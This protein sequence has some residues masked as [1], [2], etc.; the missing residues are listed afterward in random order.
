MIAVNESRHIIRL[1]VRDLLGPTRGSSS[2]EPSFAGPGRGRLGQDVHTVYLDRR[3]KEARYR[4]EVTV[5]WSFPWRGYS[6]EI[7]GRLDGLL[8]GPNGVTV[9]EVKSTLHSSHMLRKMPAVKR[10]AEQCGFYCLMLHHSGVEIRRGVVVYVSL[11]DGSERPVDI[12]FDVI[13]Y[14]QLLQVRLDILIAAQV[15]KEELRDVRAEYAAGMTFPFAEIRD[16]QDIM[17]EDVRGVAESG[18]TLLCS[19]PTGT[20]KTVAAL[21]PMVREALRVNTRLFFVTAKV[22]QQELAL[23]TLRLILKPE[24]R[25]CAVQITSKERTCPENDSRCVD[26]RC[27]A[28]DN[29]YF[30]LHRSGIL[31]DLLENPVIDRAMIEEAAAAHQFCA[32]ELSLTLAEYATVIVADFNYVFDPNVQLK[33]FFDESFSDMLLVVDEAHNLPK[34]AQ[35]YYSPELDVHELRGFIPLCMD[36]DLDV[37]RRAGALLNQVCAHFDGV[38]R[39]LAEEQGPSEWYVAEPDRSWFERLHWKIESLILDYHLFVAIEQSRPAPFVPVQTQGRERLVDPLLEQLYA[40]REYCRCCDHDPDLFAAVWYTEG[41]F[42]L[43]CLDA[44]PFLREKINGFHG[45]VCMS[46]TLTPFPFFSRVL[47]VDNVDTLM[48]DLPSPFPVENRLF[49]VCPDVD[50]TYK[51][52]SASA[53]QIGK[54]LVE[55]MSLRRGNYLAFFSSFAFRDE[56]VKTMEL[57]SVRVLLQTSGMD[58]S[59][60][61]REMEANRDETLLLCAVHGGV[62]SEGV[63]FPGHMA[64][65]AFLV[66]PGLPALTVEQELIRA[67]YERH[68]GAGFEYAYVY[69]GLNRVV[70]SGGRVIRSSTDRGIVILLGKRFVDP[71]YQEKLPEYWQKEI[72]CPEDLKAEVKQFWEAADDSWAF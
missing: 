16:C 46:A 60:V 58:T 50:T 47:G 34:R 28:L 9:E 19:A 14:E 53:A 30:R 40:I 37:Y 3:V 48:L 57:G 2:D 7:E 23:D 56:V 15:Q 1:A 63:D 72:G 65:G 29:F 11:L 62:F 59:G 55:L 31:T 52:R 25:A 27:P 39:K 51:K 12:E 17:V 36:E 69:P 54:T 4:K 5:K 35:G 32:F 26:R 33:R 45:S 70:Q 68:M 18:R 38:L 71:V 43:L 22:S 42:K 24:G 20:G 21:F 10:H 41:R 8:E 44:A 61:L 6:V 13:R 49:A 67:Y 66:G 64:V